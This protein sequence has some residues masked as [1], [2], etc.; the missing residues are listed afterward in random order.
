MIE[1]NRRIIL[2]LST[3]LIECSALS[4]C[5]DWRLFRLF[6][7]FSI[8]QFHDA[9]CSASVALLHSLSGSRCLSICCPGHNCRRRSLLRLP[10]PP[11]K[12]IFVRKMLFEIIILACRTTCLF[13]ENTKTLLNFNDFRGVFHGCL[14]LVGTDILHYELRLRK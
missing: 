9:P 4:I 1:S 8:A 3:N 12:T 14:K 6:I 5:S 11:K 7:A 2:S 13:Y 10:P